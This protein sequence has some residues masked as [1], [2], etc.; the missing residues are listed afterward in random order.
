MRDTIFAVSTAL[1][2]SA[3]SVLRMSG[4]SSFS[5]LEKI[6]VGKFPKTRY[7]TLKRIYWEEE[8]VDR[9]LVITFEKNHSYTGENTV[10]IHCHGSIAIIEKLT[11]VLLKLGPELN[12]RPAEEGE[13][14]RQAFYNGKLDLIQ[15]EGLSDLLR[16]ETEAQRKISLDQLEGT[17]SKKVDDWKAKMIS[18]LAF[19]EADIDFTD[20]DIG[21]IEV[22]GMINSF[23]S[24][25][26]KELDRFQDAKTAREGIEVAIVGPPNAG[27]STLIN[28]LSGR[29][30][31]ITSKIAGTTR[32]IIESRTQINGINVTFLDTAGLRDTRD[33]IEKKGIT[34]VK[35]RL[36]GVFIK[37]FLINK[38][39]DLRKIGIRADEEDIILKAKA[40]KGNN[41]AYQGVS[42]KSGEGVDE[43]LALIE[44]KL[45]KFYINSG[46][47]ATKRQETKIKDLLRILKF[48]IMDIESGL[49]IEILAEKARGGLKL[50]EE[51]TGKI[52]TEEVLGIIFKSFCIGK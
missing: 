27:K 51:L 29:E 40:D 35:K 33:T 9:C 23:I 36:R 21:N 31:S 2:L 46:L 48:L 15:V 44:K 34:T 12:L 1:G 42:G 8:V 10:E 13:F 47:I 4:P 14:T 25:L 28:Y 20:Q 39:E 5:V 26:K 3:I 16:A 11:S 17:V 41:T 38:E 6:T 19:L 45:P 18:I 50:I 30:V 22:T 37:I 7:A 24:V 52:D 43:V 32:D 49:D